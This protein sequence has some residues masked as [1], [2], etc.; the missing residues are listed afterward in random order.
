MLRIKAPASSA[1]L[2]PGFDCLGLALDVCNQFDV[3]LNETDILENVEDRYNN[4][5]NLFLQAYRAGCQ[6]IGISDHVRVNFDCQIPSTR[7]M[8]SSAAFIT[9][10]VCA[11]SALH[12][13]ALSKDE[14]FQIISRMEGHPD[15]TAPCL[16]GGLTCSLKD[17]DGR[18]I[19]RKMPLHDSWKFTLLVPDFEVSTKKAREILPESYSRKAVSETSSH[20]ILLMHALAEGDE[21]LLNT[22]CRDIIHEPYRTKLIDGYDTVRTIAETDTGGKPAVSG[23]GPALLLIS[24]KQLSKEAKM[25]IAS[26]QEHSWNIIE[27]RIAQEGIAIQGISK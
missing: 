4:S 9:A 1:N 6:A 22:A 19:T 8:G 2:G 18:F 15:N 13:N 7:G 17:E 23:S 11:A 26:I 3:C 21:E 5:D 14:I 16:Y 20:A 25:K 12:N 24:K 27:T 10:G